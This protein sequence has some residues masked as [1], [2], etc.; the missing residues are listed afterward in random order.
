V[1]DVWIARSRNTNELD[2]HTVHFRDNFTSSLSAKVGDVL[3]PG[4]IRRYRHSLEVSVCVRA[5][6]AL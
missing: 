6:L 3:A 4:E 2:Q 5:Y 1:P